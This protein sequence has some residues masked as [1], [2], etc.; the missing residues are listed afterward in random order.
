VECRAAP[1][2]VWVRLRIC[3]LMLLVTW[4]ATVAC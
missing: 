1:S 3:K 2:E 4:R